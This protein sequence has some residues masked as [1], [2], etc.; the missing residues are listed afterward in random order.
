VS[1]RRPVRR[2][3]RQRS[4]PAAPPTDAAPPSSVEPTDG[5]RRYGLAAL[6]LAV[7][8]GTLLERFAI[9]VLPGEALN[10]F[11]L[12][13]GLGIALLV[14]RLYRNFM[15][16]TLARQRTRRQGSGK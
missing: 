6:I 8:A 14:T 10:V 9:A 5:R 15:R 13:V 11:H 16:R 7:L 12:L 3:R 2:R 1:D 4:A